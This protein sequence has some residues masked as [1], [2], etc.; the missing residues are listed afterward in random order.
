MAPGRASRI[1]MEMARNQNLKRRQRSHPLE[2]E[3]ARSELASW[4]PREQE[5]EGW[6]PELRLQWSRGRGREV[7]LGSGD[8][9]GEGGTLPQG[10]R[11][12]RPL[13]PHT[14][15][16]PPPNPFTCPLPASFL[17]HCAPAAH[18]TCHSLLLCPVPPLGAR[19]LPWR[20]ILA[21]AEPLEPRA[22]PDS[23]CPGLSEGGRRMHQRTHKLLR[24]RGAG[25]QGSRGLASWCPPTSRCFSLP[26]G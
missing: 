22:E 1:S 13:C 24:C 6:T 23:L 16:P 4:Q 17:P 25:P 10:S 19:G 8:M 15:R 7:T 21:P 14:S 9:D 26:L 18:A 20:G 2:G 3:E 12:H 5:E 11:G